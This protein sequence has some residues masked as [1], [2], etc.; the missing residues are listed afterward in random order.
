MVNLAFRQKS[1]RDRM[2]PGDRGLSTPALEFSVFE[3]GRE[4]EVLLY[5]LETNSGNTFYTNN[6]I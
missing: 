2:C 3:V 1:F 6:T 5:I 4:N